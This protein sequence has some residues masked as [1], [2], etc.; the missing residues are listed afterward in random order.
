MDFDGILPESSYLN[1]DLDEIKFELV[2]Q[3][4]WRFGAIWY[5]FKTVKSG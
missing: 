2:D 5:Y 4:Y 3:E 1:V